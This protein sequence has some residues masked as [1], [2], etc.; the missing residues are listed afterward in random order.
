MTFS[1]EERTEDEI[2]MAHKGGLEALDRSLRDIRNCEKP[3]GGLIPAD[4]ASCQNW[5][6]SRRTQGMRKIILP[7]A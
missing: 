5:H 2:S 6:S 7:L 4:P 1:Q 3:F